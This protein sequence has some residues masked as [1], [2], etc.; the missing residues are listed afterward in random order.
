MYANGHL[1]LT[2]GGRMGT[3]GETWVCGLRLWH[4]NMNAANP[5]VNPTARTT[6]LAYQAAAIEATDDI[7]SILAAL[8]VDGRSRVNGAAHLDW[9]KL[10][11]VDENGQQL[12]GVDTNTHLFESDLTGA[13]GAGPFE[14]AICA[15]LRTSL[16]R[17][18][19]HAGRI[20]MPSTGSSY[21]EGKIPAADCTAL[22]NSVSERLYAINHVTSWGEALVSGSLTP[23]V[24]VMSTRSGKNTTTGNGPA[25][26]VTSVDVGEV[27]DVQRRRRR[28]LAENYHGS[29]LAGTHT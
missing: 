10:N 18:R 29:I 20:Y 7:A 14:L 22:A 5:K 12:D 2:W 26:E 13:V 4:A 6:A 1:R 15:T 25:F 24:H 27:P 17:G 8:H 19:A 28:G 11:F 9:C 3:L 16:H 23:V 21:T